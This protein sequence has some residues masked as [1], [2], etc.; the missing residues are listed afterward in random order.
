MTRTRTASTRA[1]ARLALALLLALGGLLTGLIEPPSPAAAQGLPT[2]RI[3]A[4]GENVT[5]IQYLLRHHGA[6]VEVDG[7]FG[8]Q[9]EGAVRDFQRA[10]NLTVDGVVGQR[11]WQA[12]FV[13]VK[14]VEMHLG[15]AYR[16][17]GV[18]SRRELAPLI[19][20]G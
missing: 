2:V 18:S 4:T 3:G 16:K 14:T 12:L 17:L 19:P 5:T 7:D 20:A 11:T 8:P 15:N 13:T 6:E 1:V 10:K 9:T